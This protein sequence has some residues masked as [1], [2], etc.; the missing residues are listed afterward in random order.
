[1][2]CGEVKRERQ[3]GRGREGMREERKGRAWGSSSLRL[4]SSCWGM[5]CMISFWGHCSVF[6]GAMPREV[7]G[8][9]KPWPTPPPTVTYRFSP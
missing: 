6:L 9:G 7:S 8:G 4:T 5:S 3:R 2:L 1:M